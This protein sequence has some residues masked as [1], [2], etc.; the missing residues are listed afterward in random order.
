MNS[1]ANHCVHLTI[2]IVLE[3]HK[4]AITQFGGSDGLRDRALLES[5][6]AAP[7]AT[8]GGQSPFSDAVDVAAAYL[9]YLCSNHPFIDG[10]KRVALGSCLVFL[11]LNGFMPAPDSEHWEN[12]TLAVAAGTLER[13]EVT[14]ILRG[15]LA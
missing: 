3:I 15:L 9:Y 6:I 7:Q 5:A 8:F 12:L 2:D 13:D 1:D 4:E 10:N 11:Q 14:R